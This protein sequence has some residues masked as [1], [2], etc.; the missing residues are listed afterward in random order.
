MRARPGTSVLLVGLLGA[1]AGCGSVAGQPVP[2][3]IPLP[4]AADAVG[5]S[6]ANLAEAG[7][8][9]Y[10]GTLRTAGSDSPKKVDITVARSGEVLGTVTV[11]DRPATV[12]VAGRTMYLKGPTEFWTALSGVA[13]TNGAVVSDRWV[14][15]PTSVL[16]LDI[17]DV[18]TPDLLSQQLGRGLDKVGDPTLDKR[19]A[20]DLGGIATVT[21]DTDTARLTLAQAAPNGLVRFTQ[22]KAGSSDTAM[23]T[24][25]DFTVADASTTQPK[26]YTDLA[27]AA[28]EL[29]NAVDLLTT[30][31]EGSHKFD[32]CDAAKCSIVVEFTNPAKTAVR[33]SVR[34]LWKG[35]DNPI[36]SC[37]AQVGPVEPGAAS[38]ATCTLTSPE[39]AQFYKKANSVAGEHG[40]SAEWSTVVL[41]DAPDLASVTA[42]ATAKPSAVADGRAD[43]SHFVY[44]ISHGTT[45]GGAPQVWKYG[46][47]AGRY[48]RDDVAKQVRTCLSVTQVVCTSAL[49]T[50]AEDLAS[51]HALVTSLVSDS[52]TANGRCPTGQW[53]SCPPG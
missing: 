14:R 46:V 6:L 16:G 42:H 22:P 40:Y 41:A 30:V 1:V 15:T 39:W 44:T 36:G 9:H 5:Q 51:A 8:V 27:A 35:D 19:T 25:L 24:D 37:E 2:I 33:V 21:A 31:K 20:S 13:D 43:G 11:A 53:V 18:F 48:W 29:P 4:S 49:V 17:A 7:A 45:P 38:S 10:V 12:L 3:D 23:A 47:G 26:L 32:G 52:R 28:A 34:A 50:A